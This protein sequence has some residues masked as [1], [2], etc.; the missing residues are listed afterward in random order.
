MVAPNLAPGFSDL[1]VQ[2][3]VN[4]IPVGEWQFQY[5]SDPVTTRT[6]Q[7]PKA[8]L[9]LSN[10]AQ[11]RFHVLGPI[12]SPAEI[13]EGSDARKLSL[14]FLELSLEKTQ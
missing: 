8:A 3:T 6:L 5:S 4:K 1:S 2:V 13:G 7:I 12:R 9:I 14:A 11:I 10:P